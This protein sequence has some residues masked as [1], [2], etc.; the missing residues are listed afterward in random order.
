MM[1]PSFLKKKPIKIHSEHSRIRELTK[2]ERQ[3]LG[4]K[5]KHVIERQG[6]YSEAKGY[7][8]GM[9]LANILYPKE[10]I[11]PLASKYPKNPLTTYSKK[12]I[13]T[14][15]SQRGIE[16]YYT[17]PDKQD[18]KIHLSKTNSKAKK[19]AQN[20]YEESGLIFN[21]IP[22]NVGITRLRKLIFFEL[23]S[24]EIPKLKKFIQKMP[25]S[26][27]KK[28]AQELLKALVELY[29]GKQNIN[30]HTKI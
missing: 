23:A 11:K 29:P 9:T 3:T 14:K 18:Y 4:F 1:V 21:Q 20:I 27:R 10:T 13:L 26:L 8:L 12:V 16:N 25:N 15:T 6:N 19:R 7:S 17:S 22:M 2:K 30:V 28:Q 5:E 24:I